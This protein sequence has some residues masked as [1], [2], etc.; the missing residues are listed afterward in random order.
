MSDE[1]WSSGFIRCMGVRLAGD[2][3]RDVDERGEPIIGDTL[4]LLFNAHHEPIPFVLPVTKAEHHWER[5]LDTADHADP[6]QTWKA[7]EPYHLKERSLAVLRTRLPE[8]AGQAMSATQ[9]E[10][11]AK[12]TQ[13]LPQP[14]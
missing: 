8:E 2:L 5:L 14:K 6:T 7:G 10:T 9:M 3:I 1:A 12:A 13:R 4:L 11:M